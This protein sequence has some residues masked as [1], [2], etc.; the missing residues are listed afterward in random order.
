MGPHTAGKRQ[1]LGWLHADR[2]RNSCLGIRYRL[3][4]RTKFHQHKRHVWASRW[5]ASKVTHSI[6]GFW[7]GPRAILVETPVLKCVTF[8]DPNDTLRR[9]VCIGEI[10]AFLIDSETV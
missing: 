10:L 4:A 6:T 2:C 7:R 9:V 8:L 5:D 1:P 3:P